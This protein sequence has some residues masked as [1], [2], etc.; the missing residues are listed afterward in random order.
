[1]SINRTYVTRGSRIGAFKYNNDDQLE[2]VGKIDSVRNLEGDLSSPTK[3]MLHQRD[4]RL[5]MLAPDDKKAVFAM[6]LHRG[7]V[8]EEWRPEEGLDIRSMAPTTKY[9][10]LSTD[11]TLTAVAKNALFSIDPRTK[12]KTAHKQMYAKA[13]KFTCISAID[14]DPS[15]KVPVVTGTET[16]EISLYSQVGQRAKTLLPGL[17]DPIIG[18]DVTADGKWILA[19]TSAY[20]LVIPT[21]MPDDAKGRTG[22]EVRMGKQKPVPRKLQLDPLEVAKHGMGKIGFT[23]AHFNVGEDNEAW[24]V[25]S[26]GPF[27]VTW[28]FRKVQQNVRSDYKIKKTTSTVVADQ[29][30]YNLDDQAVVSTTDNVYLEKRQLKKKKATSTHE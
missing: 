15:G 12:E 6:D 29:F 19:T 26:T 18:I 14:A 20:L 10:Q 7:E 27:I 17:G 11:P 16:G 1:M 4:S 3:S 8:I 22:F 25:T 5:L 9:N 13:P 21:E 30:R 23:P 24:I 28:N 2:Y